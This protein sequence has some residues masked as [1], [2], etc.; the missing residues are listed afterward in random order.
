MQARKLFSLFFLSLMVTA[1]LQAAAVELSAP[2]KSKLSGVFG[3]Q[4]DRVSEAPIEGVLEVTYGAQIFYVSKDGRYLINGEVFDLDSRTNLTKE[5]LSGARLNMMAQVD[6]SEMIV[7][8]AKGK[9]KHV[10]SVFTDI[11]CVYCRKLHQGMEEM[12]KL[13]ITVRYL[14]FPRAGLNSPSYN[15]AVSVWCADDRHKAMDSAKNEQKVSEQRCDSAP[16]Q[17]QMELG[18]AVGVT[19]TPAMVLSDGSLVPGYVP[20]KRLLEMLDKKDD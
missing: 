12:N 17:A 15:K 2:L 9:E 18:K 16:V 14:S 19:G 13:G 6:E 4:P 3:G 10:I 1:P 20:P 11:D 8:K 5:R 7:Y